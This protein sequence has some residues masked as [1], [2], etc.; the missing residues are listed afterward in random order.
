MHRAM[1]N[2]P[3]F[4]SAALALAACAGACVSGPP[5]PVVYGGS[6]QPPR[7]HPS[8]PPAPDVSRVAPVAPRIADAHANLQCVPFVRLHTGVQIFGDA[9]TW[10]RQAA[11]R[12]PRSGLPAEGAVLVVKGYQTDARGH[13]AVV[14]RILSDRQ[15]VVDHANW[16][17]GGEI[18]VDV[19][20]FDVS[21]AND[22][23]Q[24]RVWHVPGGHWGGRVYEVEGFIFP[25]GAVL[26]AA[27]GG[28]GRER[29]R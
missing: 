7:A 22:W 15:I 13:V 6:G 20:V 5:A 1:M 23:S 25:V 9:N 29:S 2:M 16:L 27:A 11:G 24:V 19:P 21:P 8:A 26:T 4:R 28:S 3:A 18:T 12:Y 10:W 14:R 17:N